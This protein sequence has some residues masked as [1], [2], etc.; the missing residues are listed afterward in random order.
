MTREQLKQ[1]ATSDSLIAKL[2]FQSHPSL[3]VELLGDIGTAQATAEAIRA[4]MLEADVHQMVGIRRQDPPEHQDLHD[5]IAAATA[6]VE[7]CFE[8]VLSAV[9]L[10]NDTFKNCKC[11]GCQRRRGIQNATAN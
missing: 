6:S 11:P 3:I 4:R 7:M 8:T 9:E 5:A 10:M 1:Y 2:L